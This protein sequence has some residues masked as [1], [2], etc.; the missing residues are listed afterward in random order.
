MALG[1]KSNFF[2]EV[3]KQ[4][5]LIDDAKALFIGEFES[6]GIE[7]Y[8]D[9]LRAFD[10]F[11]QHPSEYDGSTASQDLYDITVFDVNQ[12]SYKLEI[13]SVKHDFYYKVGAF[14]NKVLLRK[15]DKI[16]KDDMSKF[17]KSGFEISKRMFL[18]FIVREII[19]YAF[20]KRLLHLL[21]HGQKADYKYAQTLINNK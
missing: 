7:E 20:W 11:I 14:Y 12:N 6:R 17:S 5:Y 3:S 16:L 13:A 2:K 4:Q 10:Y 19:N 18:L 8:E 9:D 1:S 21:K 15:A